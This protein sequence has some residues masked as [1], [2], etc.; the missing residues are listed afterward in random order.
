[1]NLANISRYWK[2]VVAFVGGLGGVWAVVAAADLSTRAG[3]YASI[4]AIV[5]AIGVYL[6]KNK[7]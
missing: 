5:T 2:A 7:P 6:A 1:M 4:P 3:L